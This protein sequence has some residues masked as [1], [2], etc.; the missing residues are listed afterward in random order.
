MLRTH[1]IKLQMLNI[2]SIVNFDIDYNGIITLEYLFDDA[3]L[4]AEISI[5][6]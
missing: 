3:N 1:P 4:I 6:E 2:V 5:I